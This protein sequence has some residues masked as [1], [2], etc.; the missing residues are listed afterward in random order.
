MDRLVKEVGEENRIGYAYDPVGNRLREQR[1]GTTIDYQYGPGNRLLKRGDTDVLIDERGNLVVERSAA[2]GDDITAQR[3]F[4]YNTRNRPEAFYTSDRLVARYDY[5]PLGLRIG[6]T[7]YT[8]KGEAHTRFSYAPDTRLLAEQSDTKTTHYIWLGNQPIAAIEMEQN[9]KAKPAIHYLHADHLHTPRVATDSAGN[10]VWRWRS[11]AFGTTPAETDPD[12]DGQHVDIA[13]RFPGQYHDEESGLYYNVFRYYDP[14]TGRY[15]QTDP[16]GL[17][18]GM[19]SFAYAESGPLKKHD[20]LGLLVEA[21]FDRDTGSLTLTDLDT[22]ETVTITAFSGV[23]D[24]YSPAPPGVYTISD[25][26]W[27]SSLSPDYYALVRHDEVINDYAEGFPSNYPDQVPNV[28]G[29]LRLHFGGT[30]HGC[31][32]VPD[33]ESWGNARRLLENTARGQPI[34]IHNEAFPNFGTLTIIGA[35]FGLPP[36]PSGGGEFPP[37]PEIQ[38]PDLDIP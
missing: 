37:L 34:L 6:K 31:V 32:T 18:G 3:R 16:I 27:G 38:I 30:S 10:I 2:D 22:Q 17:L 15:T 25:F 8:E 12:G 14:A 20:P 4:D 26:P 33:R 29:H 9:G 28:M 35:G 36:S 19:N 13:L 5:N 7:I 21:T 11:D 1:N 23:E 24:V